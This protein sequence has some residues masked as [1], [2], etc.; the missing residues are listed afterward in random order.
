MA[1][2]EMTKKTVKRNTSALLIVCIIWGFVGFTFTQRYIRTELTGAFFG[3]FIACVIVIQ[4]ERQIIL[5]GSKNTWLLVFRGFIAILMALIGSLIIDQIIFKEDIE[6]KKITMLEKEVRSI[7]STKSEDLKL[8]THD[9]D[10][11]LTAKVLERKMLL[12]DIILNP[13][14]KVTD[15]QKRAIPLSTTTTDSTNNRTTQTKLV[16]TTELLTTS[17]ENPKNALLAPIDQQILDM[18]RQK[19]EKEKALLSL[20]ETVEKDL[21]SKV[22]FLDE[23]N[24][25]LEIM[26]TSS[27]AIYIWVTWLL[28]LLGLECFIL[29]SKIGGQSDDYDET[30]LHQMKLQKQKLILLSKY[31]NDDNK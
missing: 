8:Q 5:A 28:F 26:R 17:R 30:V 19:I 1:S 11:N 12:D 24:V 7:Y 3:A 16:S 23:I 10:S 6:K 29:T 21:N 4:I 31:G 15:V 20:R 18:Q 14:I 25:M 9:L 22:G 2:S 27:A 13:M